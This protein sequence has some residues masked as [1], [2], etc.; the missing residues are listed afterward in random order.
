MSLRTRNGAARRLRQTT[1]AVIATAALALTGCAADGAGG[2]EGELQPLSAVTFLPLESF[3]FT[4]EMVAYAGG[5]FEDHGLDVDLQAVQGSAAAIQAVISGATDVTRAST[6]DSMPPFEQGQPLLAVGT[7][8]HKSN[9][10]VA[11]AASHPI[12]DGASMAGQTIGMG[13]IGG[14]SEK[15][16]DLMLHAEGVDPDSVTRQSVPVTGATFELVKQGQ[17]AGYIVSLDTSIAIAQQNED[18]VIDA[19]GLDEV[20]DFQTWL[21]SEE[22]AADPEKGPRVTAFMAAIRDAVQFVIDDAPNDY[23]NVLEMLRESGEFQFAALDDDAIAKEALDFYTTETW[24]NPETG[25]DIL[26]NDQEK[27][28]AAYESYA[29]TGLVEGSHDPSAWMTDDLL[30]TE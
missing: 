8:A 6:I 28:A 9:I 21:V 23:V 13:S 17:L 19:A 2:G 7:M 30:P 16:L 20:P 12:E 3:T 24:V 22:T 11:S 27:W 18:A 25:G 29:G 26:V 4:P 15:A 5:F 14:T 1:A 10:R